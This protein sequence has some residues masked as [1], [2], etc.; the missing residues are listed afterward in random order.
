MANTSLKS[1]TQTIVSYKIYLKKDEFG[2]R[3]DEKN[4]IINYV[5]K[6]KNPETGYYEDAILPFFIS[7]TDL[8]KYFWLAEW[9]EK[10]LDVKLKGKSIVITTEII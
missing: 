1:I 7:L 10:Q 2:N 6:R 5:W 9:D 3:I 4:V 8:L